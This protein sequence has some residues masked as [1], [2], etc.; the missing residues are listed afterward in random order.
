MTNLLV[1]IWISIISGIIVNID[2]S[3]PTT[4]ILF[5][6]T[7]TCCFVGGFVN[8]GD[9]KLETKRVFTIFSGSLSIIGL[10]VQIVYLFIRI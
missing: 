3:K 1:F 10:L 5:T 4:L 2:S 7:Q 9:I 8:A 6:L